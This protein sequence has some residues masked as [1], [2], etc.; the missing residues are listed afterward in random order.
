MAT[1]SFYIRHVLKDEKKIEELLE[2]LN[3]PSAGICVREEEVKKTLEE[4]ER[5]KMF[6]EQWKREKKV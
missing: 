5:G 3:D 1:I 4:L 2:A 6:L